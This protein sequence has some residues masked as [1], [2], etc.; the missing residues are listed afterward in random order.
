MDHIIKLFRAFAATTVVIALVFA[1]A[2]VEAQT[3]GMCGEIVEDDIVTAH[4]TAPWWNASGPADTPNDHHLPPEDGCCRDHHHWCGA[5]EIRLATAVVDAVAREDV[6]Y[7]AG[8]V[9]ASSAVIVDSRQAIQVPD[10]DD[11]FIVGHV[12][13]DAAL[14]ASLRLAVAELTDGQ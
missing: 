10:C 1:A 7:L 3:C 8:L 4:W 9:A 13:A 14:I 2:P 11:E 6:A 5:E 12:P